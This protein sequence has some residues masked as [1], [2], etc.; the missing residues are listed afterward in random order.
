MMLRILKVL[1]TS[2][3]AVG[4]LA[5]FGG[6]VR[7]GQTRPDWIVG[8]AADGLA[9]VPGFVG[10]TLAN[11]VRDPFASTTTPDES[12]RTA[13]YVPLANHSGH[14]IE[15]LVQ[16]TDLPGPAP[17][18]GKRVLYG[19]FQVDGKPQYAVLVL[20]EDM[21]IE[22]ALVIDEAML[23]RH[24]F[25]I[26]QAP[27]P[28]G[29]ALL[30]DGSMLLGFD[31]V[32]L[33]LRVSACGRRIW[34]GNERITHAIHPDAAQRFAWGVG[35]QDNL[36]QFDIATG[37]SGRVIDWRE[38]ARANP[39]LGVFE[40]RRFDPEG[41]GAN[42]R[43]VESTFFADPV[44]INDVEPLPPQ[45]APAFP[46]FAPGDLLVSMRSL[47]LVFVLDPKT[48]KVKWHTND[49]TLRQHDPDWENDGTITVFD[50]QNGR[51]FSR[52][53]RFDPTGA[54]APEVMVDGA[55]YD[56][57]S[58]IR[59]KHQT[60]DNGGMLI[61]STGQGRAFEIDQAGQMVWELVDHDPRNKARNFILSQVILFPS[62]SQPIERILKCPVS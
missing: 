14:K 5:L 10:D 2:V 29:F 15:G 4:V 58:R 40:M 19:I 37:K 45:L 30:H 54:R 21:A 35:S 26:G 57:Y 61:T 25:E 9:R 22:R 3:L 24:H 38:I 41:N 62:T 31:S 49:V 34:F 51:Q 43:G 7:A 59:G 16:R 52:I 12:P 42:V 60:L 55:K 18:A 11:L 27:S 23:V 8:R 39:Q 28:H 17:R 1:R 6:A 53:V 44:H 48:L 33:P 13:H 20:G 50:N 32:Y 36:R 46:E 56:F 47:N